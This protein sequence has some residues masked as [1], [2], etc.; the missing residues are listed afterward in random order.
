MKTYW[1]RRLS[2]YFLIIVMSPLL[3]AWLAEKPINN[4]M[5]F[6]PIPEASQPQAF[7]WIVFLLITLLIITSLSFFVV[8]IVSIKI[9]QATDQKKIKS[10]PF[11][12]WSGVFFLLIFWIIAWTRL[13][14]FESIQRFTFTPLWLV[15]ILVINA[16]SF[17]RTG[18]CCLTDRTAYFIWLFPLSAAFWWSF[19]YLN[20]FVSNWY[21]IGVSDLSPWQYFLQCTLSFSTVLPAILSTSELLNTFPRISNGLDTFP[22]FHITKPQFCAWFL[23]NIS[24]SALMGL[25]IWPQYLFSLVWLIPISLITGLHLLTGQ[26]P[27]L[28]E[29]STG[30]WQ[31]IWRLAIAG[32]ICGFFWEMWNI[33]SLAHWKYN[34]PYVHH[35]MIFEM[36]LIGYAGYLPFGIVCGLF[37]DFIMKEK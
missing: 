8:K 23:I 1:F 36:P 4:Y 37:V 25:A 30:N 31:R 13:P 18:H 28:S 33:N 11:W 10:F 9:S 35:F 6:P 2:A 12:G 15:Y 3:G 27:L 22:K 19:E 26:P 5:A 32:L 34:V 21:Y 16:L 20:R 24:V 29:I 14:L 7:S 17:H